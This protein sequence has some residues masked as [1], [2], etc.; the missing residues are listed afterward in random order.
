MDRWALKTRCLPSCG[1]SFGPRFFRNHR[2][3]NFN[4]LTQVRFVSDATDGSGSADACNLDY[5]KADVT[6]SWPGNFAGRDNLID[7]YF[8]QKPGARVAIM[9]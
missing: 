5:K 6:V 7:Q 9:P 2:Q 1:G 3:H 8:S 4:V